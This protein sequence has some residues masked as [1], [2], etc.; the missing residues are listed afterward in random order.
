VA[1]TLTLCV[2]RKRC[3]GKISR[4]SNERIRQCLVLGAT[5]VVN[6]VVRN[7]ASKLATPWLLNLLERKPRKLAAMALAEKAADL[8]G[9][10]TRNPSGPA[11]NVPRKQAAHMTAI[12]PPPKTCRSPLRFRGRRGASWMAR[13]WC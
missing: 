8:F 9:A 1:L 3:L 4:E 7:K 2:D 10:A 13:L 12:A 11:V 5:S 6:A